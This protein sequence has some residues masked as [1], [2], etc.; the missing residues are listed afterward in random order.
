MTEAEK[1]RTL[2]GILAVT[3][4]FGALIGLGLGWLIGETGSSLAAGALIGFLVTSGM[5]AFD[6]SWAVGLMP[7]AWREAPFLV[8]IFTRSL[9]WLAII[10]VGISLPLLTIAGLSL[11]DLVDQTFVIAVA[12]SFVGALLFNFVGQVNRL[13]GRGVLVS[14]MLGRYHRP[15]E[16]VRVFLLIDLRGSTQIAEQLGNLRYHEFLRR[17]ISDVT[18]SVVRHGGEVHRYVGDEV[19]LT[20]TADQGLRD[21]RC[22]RAVFAISDALD[23]ARDEYESEFGVVPDFWAGLHLGPVIAGEIGTIKQE[24]AFLGDTVN[25][26]ARIQQAGKDHGH[27]FLASYEVISKVDLPDDIA[28]ESLGQV[29]LRGIEETVELL[30]VAR[31]NHLSEA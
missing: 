29:E 5:V 22:I 24:I 4:P 10:V 15:R 19:I 30:S 7:R 3:V 13:L 20:W 28:A 6:V 12:A 8:V 9:V 11:A 26:A 23:A 1:W 2:A 18:T 14:L 16:E 21:A 17:F 25:A 31:V 27:Q